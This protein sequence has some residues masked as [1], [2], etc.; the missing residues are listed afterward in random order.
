MS[1]T[2][3]T[4]LTEPSSSTRESLPG[5][6]VRKLVPATVRI[7]ANGVAA[8][9]RTAVLLLVGRERRN[10]EL[11]K[12]L[13]LDG[14]DVRRAATIGTLRA[15]RMSGDVDLL[16]FGLGRDQAEAL[17]CLRAQRA[18]EL[19][20]R[21]SA[22]MRIIWLAAGE[23][24]TEMLRA[25]DAGADDVI[26]AS[27]TYAELHARLKA[28]L[29]RSKSLTGS[30]EVLEVGPLEID[31]EAHIATLDGKRL[32]LRPLDFRLLVLLAR[33]PSRVFERTDL[34][35]LVWGYEPSGPTRIVDSAASRL[36]R[37][38]EAAGGESWV[39]MVWG[40]GYR[41]K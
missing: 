5:A 39:I 10:D 23:V 12:Q 3:I 1:T 22:D 30:M 27:H 26:C 8:P 15:E 35:R 9:R 36:R 17:A 40:I 41:L 14:Y 13:E 31:V 20:P 28:V 18:G 11:A 37:K 4:G 34:L 2:L 25:F 6:R 33:A 32:D 24:A 29:R 7:S 21:V 19:G 38:L 16:I